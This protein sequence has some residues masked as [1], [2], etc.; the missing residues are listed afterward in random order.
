MKRRIFTL[1]FFVVVAVASAQKKNYKNMA[2][3]V[4]NEMKKVLSLNQEQCD[5]I[6]PIHLDKVT[7][8]ETIKL[9]TSLNEAEKKQAIEEEYRAATKKFSKIL[10]KETM[11]KW[12]GYIKQK[13]SK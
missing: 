3:G 10:G 13:F 5:A 7:K 2:Q 9:N 11:D 6:Y 12:F 4:T 1:V 8:I